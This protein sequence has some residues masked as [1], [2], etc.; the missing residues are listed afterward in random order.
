MST[1]Q[2]RASKEKPRFTTAQ[3]DAVV[4]QRLQPNFK[5][6]VCQAITYPGVLPLPR[7]WLFKSFVVRRMFVNHQNCF[8]Q[9]LIFE[10]GSLISQAVLKLAMQLRM[11]Y[12][13]FYHQILEISDMSPCSGLCGVG[14]QTQNLAFCQALYELTYITS[15]TASI[16]VNHSAKI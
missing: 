14:D 6:G 3:P 5:N 4:T 10:T 7:S 12:S 1:D 9:H 15:L 2:C 8:Y 16:F 13:C 11:T